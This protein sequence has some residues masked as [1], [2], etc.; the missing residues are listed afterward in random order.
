MFTKISQEAFNELQVDAGMI[1]NN[2]DPSDPEEPADEDIVTA[3]TGGITV[4]CT[5]TYSDWGEDVDNC[6]PNLK[7]LKHL[8]GWNCSIETTALG[9]SP[10]LIRLALGAAD[11]E[12]S[13]PTKIV[14]RRKL[15][16]TD[17]SDLWWVGDKADG[18]L[19]AVKLKNGLSTGG[20]TLKTTKDGK[21]NV[22]LSL[23]GHV[24]IND[25]DT[26]PME[27]YST[28]GETLAELTVASVAG[29]TQ[30]KTAVT[31]TGYTKGSSESLKYKIGDAAEEVELDE[32]LTTGWISWNGTDEIETTAGKKITV[33]VV[34]T[35]S[36]K[37]KAA[38]SA[39][40]V[41]NAGA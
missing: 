34:V 5:P 25:Q 4:N 36:N 35:A 14:P 19:V 13:D 8:D 30:G 24:S 40:T 9:T 33:A 27:F 10:S 41:I 23:T 15:K 28:E 18:G 39:T 1:L 12:S 37:A 26:M 2:F 38:G 22:S 17:F 20:F 32:V 16:Q 21:G 29:T 7:E 6:P 3:T 31:Y 11:I